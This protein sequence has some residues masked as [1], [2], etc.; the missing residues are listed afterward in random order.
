MSPPV[1]LARAVHPLRVRRS[2]ASLLSAVFAAVVTLLT[3]TPLTLKWK[4][5]SETAAP[6][7]GR[8]LPSPR[9][10]LVAPLRET[11]FILNDCACP[12]DAR[13]LFC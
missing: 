7:P 11:V 3:V 9:R 5:A 4:E 12:T 1:S 8:P 13:S 2:S 6:L 10:H